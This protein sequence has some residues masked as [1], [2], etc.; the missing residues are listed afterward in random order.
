MGLELR[1]VNEW[2]ALRTV[3]VGTAQTMGGIP[4]VEESYDPKS[5]EH[6]LAGTF[7][8]EEDCARELQSL[9]R[10]LEAHD[11]QVLRPHNVP[12]LNQ[13][14]ARDVGAVVDDRIIITRMISDRAEEW[15]GIS[16]LLDSIPDHLQL[17]PSRRA[18]RGRR[19][20]ANERRDLGRFQCARRIQSLH[21]RK[22][23]PSGP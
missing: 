2:D 1:A 22:N 18:H 11:V 5:K 14:F 3:V 7:P 21:N 20:H 23:Q 19:C 9:V 17:T 13:I 10:L 8:R 16:P 12:D 6:I 4:T 15:E